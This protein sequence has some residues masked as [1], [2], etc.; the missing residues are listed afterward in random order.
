MQILFDCMEL[1]KRLAEKLGNLGSR[2]PEAWQPRLP[3]QSYLTAASWQCQT[4]S[5]LFDFKCFKC[6]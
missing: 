2:A 1:G 3:L 4:R 6:I 5:I